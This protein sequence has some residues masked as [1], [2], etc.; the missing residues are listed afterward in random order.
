MCVILKT[1]DRDMALAHYAQLQPI[2]TRALPAGWT[3]HQ[4]K[5]TDED[6]A[7]YEFDGVDGTV[8]F[9]FVRYYSDTKSYSFQFEMDA[10][11]STPRN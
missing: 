8:L 11:D 3:S 7:N 4:L 10:P 2:V 1:P 6:I 5:L 9:L